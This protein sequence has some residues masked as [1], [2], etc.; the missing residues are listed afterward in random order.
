MIVQLMILTVILAV[1]FYQTTLVIVE[2]EN[3]KL[4]VMTFISF[5]FSIFIY[6]GHF[7]LYLNYT[8]YGTNHFWLILLSCLVYTA[9]FVSMSYLQIRKFL[10]S[11]ESE[12]YP[13]YLE[14][15]VANFST[16]LGITVVGII[17]TTNI[18]LS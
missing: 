13:E 18:R 16:M 9:Y 14:I 2:T 11:V 6:A 12:S 1:I 10:N 3:F 4:S 17:I 8:H 7:L 5:L 15:A